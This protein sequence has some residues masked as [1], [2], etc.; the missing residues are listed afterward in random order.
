M[1]CWTWGDVIVYFLCTGLMIVWKMPLSAVLALVFKFPIYLLATLPFELLTEFK[2]TSFERRCAS[3]TYSTFFQFG[4]LSFT[5]WLLHTFKP[6]AVRSIFFSEF[7]AIVLFQYR[8]LKYGTENVGDFNYYPSKTIPPLEFQSHL[9]TKVKAAQ[10]PLAFSSLI[11]EATKGYWVKSKCR[12]KLPPDLVV[13]FVPGAIA[14]CASSYT[15]VEFLAMLLVEL[16]VQ[17]FS[18]PI[19]YC[20]DE[21]CYDQTSTGFG[22]YDIQVLKGWYMVSSSY[23]DTKTMFLG[24]GIGGTALLDLLL[25]TCRSNCDT[26]SQLSPKFELCCFDA[27]N[28]LM[29]SSNCFR[30]KE[31]EEIYQE[32]NKDNILSLEAKSNYGPLDSFTQKAKKHEDAFHETEVPGEEEVA[33]D[34]SVKN[35]SDT[36]DSSILY[37]C[38][39]TDSASL[40]P[41]NMST[42]LYSCEDPTP[43]VTNMANIFLSDTRHN[44]TDRAT[45]S[46][47]LDRYHGTE[48]SSDR[49]IADLDALFPDCSRS[50]AAPLIEHEQ[51]MSCVPFSLQHPNAAVILSPIFRTTADCKNVYPDFITQE[52]INHMGKIV[53]VSRN[54]EPISFISFDK[55]DANLWRSEAIPE[56]G[57]SFYFGGRETLNPEIKQFI[58]TL[59]GLGQSRIFTDCREDEV[60]SWPITNA[61]IGRTTTDQLDGIT[62]V[63]NGIARM[64]AMDCLFA[65]NTQM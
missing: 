51:F 26:V 10:S 56:R 17:G 53:K 15:Y 37:E 9:R 27:E 5:R 31:I 32:P 46:L 14:G 24:S 62:V 48:N 6:E 20:L 2:I 60:H 12:I 54:E 42:P 59:R 29:G 4:A 65:K 1:E 19:A 63:A 58:K 49:I 22:V 18:N 30:D 39:N 21:N 35:N 16:Q 8:K 50:E 52:V 23:P 64:L 43:P 13:Y 25:H 33:D 40:A 28:G 38:Y 41:R 45:D 47:A 61:Y 7:H 55:N 44:D 3:R 11:S 57:I 34:G 36:F